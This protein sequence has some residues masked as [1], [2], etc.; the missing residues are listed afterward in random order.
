MNLKEGILY[1]LNND[2]KPAVGCTEPVAIALAC[3]AAKSVIKGEVDK[4]VVSLS[5]N[6]YKNGMNVGIPGID[7]IGLDVAGALGVAKGDPSE[8]LSLLGSISEEMKQNAKT[9]LKDNKIKVELLDTPKRMYIESKIYVGSDVARAVIEDK[10]DNI[11]G[12]YLNDK[13][14]FSKENGKDAAASNEFDDSFFEHPVIDIIEEVEKLDFEDIKYMLEG[15]KMNRK[16]VEL[17]MANKLGVG[18]GHAMK[19]N[20]EK[21]LIAKDVSNLAMMMTSAASDARMS[22]LAI[23]VMSSNGSGNH[24]ITAIVPIIAYNEMFPTS[25]DRLARAVAISHLVTAY[26]KNS[27]GRL[28]SLCGCSIAAST[29]SACGITWLMG[30]KEKEIQGVIKNILANQSG[31]ICDGAKP[32]CALK[33]G[34]AAVSGVQA[35]IYAMDGYVIDQNSGIVTGT[36]EE[37]INNLGQLSQQGMGQVDNA[38]INIMLQGNNK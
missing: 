4:V 33:L 14:L 13:C 23:P 18:A 20:M 38:I 12:I 22:G 34:T 25:D 17:G 31:V 2:V 36:A 3:A 32:G 19:V 16:A 5:P 21:G 35:A 1:I 28:S 29:G 7:E 11:V 27:I 9:L 30:G 15:I 26:V 10:H 24:G 8:G 6:V 37:S